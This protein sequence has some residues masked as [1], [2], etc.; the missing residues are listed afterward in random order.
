M[1][2]QFIGLDQTPEGQKAL[3]LISLKVTEFQN[4]KPARSQT[5]SDE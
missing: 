2:F 3:Q 5:A 1:G 4:Q